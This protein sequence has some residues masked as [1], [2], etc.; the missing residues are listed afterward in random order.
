MVKTVFMVDDEPSVR[1]TV[2]QGLEALDPEFNVV[3]VE[4]GEKCFE[5]LESNL[6]PD[7][8]LLDIMMPGM[9]GWEI[10]RRLKEKLEWRSIPIV[11]LTATGDHTSRKI[12]RMISEDYI[13][14]PFKISEL[15]QRID[16]ILQT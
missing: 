8:I 2:K 11:F 13:E 7:I 9:N 16:K 12:G 5:M 3:P 14:K 10:Q 1:Y 15:K 4:S 6:V